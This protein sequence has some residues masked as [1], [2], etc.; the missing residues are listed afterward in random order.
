[1]TELLPHLDTFV[2]AAELSNFTAAARDLGLSQA[3]VSQRMQ[4]L[5]RA[6]SAPL[7]HR[8]GGQIFLTEAGQQL[9]EY[10]QRIVALHEEAR[11]EITGKKEPLTA[12]LAL[13]ASS[14]PA[15]HLLPR[16][17]ADFRRQHPHVQIRVT[18]SDSAAVC[19]E[20]EQGHV[21]LG[22]IGSKPDQPTLQHRVF[23]HDQM[24][25]IVP[26]KHPW[27]K[28]KRV[29]LEQFLNEALI[30][31]EAGSGSR[32]CLEQELARAGKSARDLRIALELGSNEA[33]KEMVLRGSG[34]AVLSTQSVS[35]E[36]AAG[37][38]SAL[39]VADLELERD[40]YA[41]W[42]SRRALSIP[43]QLFLDFLTE[44]KARG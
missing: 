17:L 28:R 16:L 14:I 21:Q 12:S 11:R 4:A 33:I 9:F 6:L 42:D 35:K 25:L 37:E 43:A 34:L 24:A 29:S 41:V 18:V 10:A 15:E 23:A 1:M 38:L 30:V 19:N 20:V 22:L 40:L 32:A 26:A 36:L 3:A 7:F 27:G 13:A 39:A 5:E 8:Q 31:R 2:K 44:K